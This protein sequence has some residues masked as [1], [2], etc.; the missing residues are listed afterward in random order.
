V[1][2]VVAQVIRLEAGLAG[3]RHCRLVAGAVDSGVVAGLHPSVLR[4]LL[5][6][7]VQKLVKATRL[8]EVTF[9]VAQKADRVLIQIA[10]EPVP[11]A[12]TPAS[13]FIAETVA[14]RGGR[15]EVRREGERVVF[16]ID[17]PGASTITALVVDDN[18]DLVHLYRRYTERTR[19]RIEHVAAGRQVFDAVRQ[20]RPD[21]VVLDVMLP[22]IDGW[23]VLTRLH[24]DPETRAIPVIVCSDVRQEELALALG[25]RRYVPKPVRRQELIQALEQVVA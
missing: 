9:T 10:G 13:E 5:L 19:F 8:G 14:A 21:V 3:S 15:A 6:V 11:A 4:Q 25:A 12:A 17:L 2:E 22:D 24:E 1:A 7:A 20:L 18:A 16:C 23:E